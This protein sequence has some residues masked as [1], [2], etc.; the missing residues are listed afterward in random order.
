MVDMNQL[1]SYMR[2]QAEEDKQRQYVNVNG[3]TLED[4]LQ[5]AAIELSLPVK[6]IEYEVLE[7]GT[8]GMFGV[9][10]KPFVVLA[11][12]AGHEDETGL[13]EEEGAFDFS[14]FEEGPKDRDGKAYVK[15]TPQGVML[16]VTP[17]E[18]DGDRVTEQEAMQ[19]IL[20]RTDADIDRGQVSKVVKLQ[21]S[22]FRRVGDLAYDPSADA[23]LS[24]EITDNEM[25]AYMTALPPGEGGAD[26]DYDTIVTFLQNSN[27]VHGFK[28]EV[29]RALDD[30]PRYR[31]PILV[32]EGTSPENGA[33]A[34]VVYNFDTNGSSVNLKETDGRVDFKELN[35]IENVVEGQ[36]LAK[37]APPGK[38]TAGRT[39]TGKLLKA[40]DGEDTEIQVGKNVRISEDGQSAY[41]E[42]NGQVTVINGKINVEPVYVVN[43]DVNLKTGNIL[44]LGTVM[45]KGNVEDGFNVKA[46]G[47]IEVMGNVGKCQLDAEGDIIVHQGVTGKGGGKVHAGKNLWSKFI[48]NATADVDGM[49]V[50]SDGIINSDVSATSKVICKG[51]R[52]SIVGGTTRAAEEINAKT[53]GS[54]AGMETVLAVGYDP[55]SK[56]RLDQLKQQ[57]S[58]HERELDDIDRNLSTLQN[59]RKQRKELPEEKL[60]YMKQLV[61][62]KQEIEKQRKQAN[63]EIEELENYL[64]QLKVTGKISASGR[65]Y[66]GVQLHIKDASLTVRNEF[67]NVTFIQEAGIVKPS[68]YE[69]VEDDLTIT[70][71]A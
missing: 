10:K 60:N 12:S 57:N 71:S 67:K 69:D 64:A 45:V 61:A 32:A 31:E 23:V 1:Q 63:S 28:E 2:Q 25:K 8:K 14:V 48:E 9:G 5:Q 34:R 55:T 7:K 11:Y 30:E 65:V 16:K 59:Q 27:V 38:G 24:V 62:K 35:I 49:V 22:E 36:V 42:I 68:K 19:R 70:K 37:K 33:D 39:V 46:S 13:G 43:G 3:E 50:V 66:P 29:L 54:V 52:A 44:F 41:A 53:L 17:P 21:E 18:G 51:K 4:A 40:T 26:P 56:E 20:E 47:N 15:L 58:D 6:K